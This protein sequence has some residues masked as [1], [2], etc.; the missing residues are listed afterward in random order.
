MVTPEKLHPGLS[1]PWAARDS[2]MTEM[3]DSGATSSELRPTQS[4]VGAEIVPYHA[5]HKMRPGIKCT[6]PSP[7]FTIFPCPFLSPSHLFAH[8]SQTPISGQLTARLSVGKPETPNL[9]FSLFACPCELVH[10]HPT[11]PSMWL[12][13]RFI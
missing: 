5:Q 8:S 12:R 10:K 11:T 7:K 13:L 6:S 4:A 3:R 9:T 2:L 1:R